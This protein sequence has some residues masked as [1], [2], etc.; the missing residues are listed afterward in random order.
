MRAST[1]TEMIVVSQFSHAPQRSLH[2]EDRECRE[3]TYNKDSY[4]D[5]A[6]MNS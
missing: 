1:T 4:L 6:D 5:E 2:R 3:N